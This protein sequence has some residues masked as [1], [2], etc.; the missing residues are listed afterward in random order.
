MFDFKGFFSTEEVKIGAGVAAGIYATEFLANLLRGMLPAGQAEENKW[1]G[2]LMSALLKG[3]VGAM[4]YNFGKTN[5]FVRYM[6]VGAWTSIILDL[7]RLV[8]PSAQ[9]LAG[10]FA[11]WAPFG[12]PAQPPAIPVKG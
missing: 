3:F 11:S 1:T 9:S 10:Q 8:L 5:T 7:F 2:F 12:Q 4:L 6:A